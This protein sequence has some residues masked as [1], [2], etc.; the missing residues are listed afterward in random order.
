MAESTK[1]TQARAVRGM[2]AAAFVLRHAVQAYAVAGGEGARRLGAALA[3]LGEGPTRLAGE[4]LDAARSAVG[5]AAAGKRTALLV[6]G[7]GIIEALP[8]IR[9]LARTGIPALLVIPSHGP[10]VGASL[11]AAGLGD[12]VPLQSLA[13]GLLVA[14]DAAQ[15]ADLLLAGLRAASDRGA[16]WAVAFELAQVGLALSNARLPEVEL[17]TRWAANLGMPSSERGSLPPPE[18]GLERYQ[19][20][21]ERFSFAIA[22]SMRDLEREVRH[23]VAP[24]IIEGARDPEIVFVAAGSA[25]HSARQAAPHVQSGGVRHAAALQVTSLRPFPAAEVVRL[26]WRARAVI[27]HEPHPEPL[28]VGGMLSDAVRASFADALTWHPGFAGIGRIPPVVTILG[29]AVSPAQWLAVAEHI[30]TAGDPPRLVVAEHSTV[31]STA[32][33]A[34][35]EIAMSEA[36]RELALRLIVDWLART[37]TT[38]SAHAN[39]PTRATVSLARSPDARGPSTVLLACAGGVFE[40]ARLESLPSGSVVVLAGD[41]PDRVLADTMRAGASR[42]IRVATLHAQGGPLRTDAAL[43]AAIRALLPADNRVDEAFEAAVSEVTGTDAKAVLAQTRAF[44]EA[45]RAQFA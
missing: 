42:G 41:F 2:E 34:R 7:D 40:P 23:P 24:V 20:D 45:L 12:L 13:V 36:E 19:R 22:A 11:P 10:D 32:P 5:S 27:V 18:Q 38:V 30:A 4:G 16:P 25:A 26:S 39:E 17:V 3:Q 28:G 31:A 35:I 15:V 29:A 43:A 1:A 9:E 8:A 33:E 14:S 21:V 37:G 44:G 6:S